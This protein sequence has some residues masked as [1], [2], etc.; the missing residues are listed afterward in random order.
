MEDEKWEMLAGQ[1]AAVRLVVAV[2]IRDRLNEPALSQA[3]ERATSSTG[4][5]MPDG[6]LRTS[7]EAEVDSIQSIAALRGP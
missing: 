1:L 3:I 5:A 7:F 4:C 2:L 6:L